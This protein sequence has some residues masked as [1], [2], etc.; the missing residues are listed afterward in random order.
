M[1][2]PEFVER[3]QIE[4]QKDPRSRVFAPLA[5]AYRK[6]GLHDEAFRVCAAGVKLHPDFAS[7]RVAFAKILLDG[8]RATEALEQL[9]K[10]TQLSPDNLLAHSMMGE[11][12]LKLRRPKEALKAYK[13]VLF[14]NPQDEK[15]LAAVRKWEFLSAD[16]YDDDLFEMRPVFKGAGTSKSDNA[17]HAETPEALAP[18]AVVQLDTQR[19]LERAVSL[20]DA[21]T[22]R[23]DV[24]SALM[25]LKN[26]RMKLGPLAEIESR[27]NLL[28][29]RVRTAGGE[30]D[31]D[32]ASP[33][34]SAGK[35]ILKIQETT[36]DD[37]PSDARQIL[38]TLLQR[39]SERRAQL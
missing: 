13:M 17:H 9:E 7:G 39:I 26:A 37:R 11:T 34:G 1:V 33:E 22:I 15:A 25:V 5:E 10:A 35:P 30:V 19:E 32:L 21:F 31:D 38:E 16:D 12:L 14:I 28:E 2:N 24:D 3:Y 27:F 36:S 8:G 20:A 6:M 29:R 4:Y 23:N 18:V